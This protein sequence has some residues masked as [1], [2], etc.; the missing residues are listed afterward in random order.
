M[1]TL[2]S[3]FGYIDETDLRKLPFRYLGKEVKISKNAV[4]IGLENIELGDF[5]RIDAF[6]LVS[7][8]SG[9]FKTGRNVHVAVGATIIANGGVELMSYSGLSHGVKI[10]SSSDDYS[11]NFMT[12]P[13]VP[14]EFTNVKSAPVL[15][16]EHVIVGSES[17]ILPGVMV[18]CGSAIGAL[19][20]VTKSL[21]EWG[22]FQG[23]PVRMLRERDRGLLEIESRYRNSTE[24]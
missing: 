18:G 23:Q 20:L 4:L 8:S 3:D 11:G 12:N 9:F 22:V 24:Y 6:A 7:A 15:L 5:T 16:G 14:K 13:T 19:S 17:V 21:S 1:A 10:F 2:P